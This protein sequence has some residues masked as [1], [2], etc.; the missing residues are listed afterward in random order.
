MGVTVK[1]SGADWK[2]VRRVARVT[3]NLPDD[4]KEP[5]TEWKRKMA[6]SKHSPLRLIQFIIEVEAPT[7]VVNHLTRHQYQLP[8]Y[9]VASA[10]PD[11]TGVERPSNEAIKK[12][13]IHV[14]ADGL[15][16]IAEYRLCGKASYETR[17]LVKEIVSKVKEIE[18]EIA[19][20]CHPRC[21]KERFCPE[22]KPCGYVNTT[23]FDERLCRYLYANRKR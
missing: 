22:F 1:R 20:Q 23:A 15:L 3:Q 2:E 8:D 6:V 11:I 14:N 18:P 7:W 4:G 10:R 16:K 21:I 17:Q 13:V 19:A 5:T 9:Y 12:A